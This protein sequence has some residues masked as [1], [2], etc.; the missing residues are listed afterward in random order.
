M[1]THEINPPK[2]LC[3]APIFE[4]SSQE[5][6]N[7]SIGE[8]RIAEAVR[9][10]KSQ[11][12]IVSKNCFD[13]TLLKDLR[14]ESIEFATK[15][16]NVSAESE[17]S[18]PYLEKSPKKDFRITYNF[19]IKGLFNSTAI[20]QNNFVFPI[21]NQLL[22]GSAVLDKFYVFMTVPGSERTE[23]HID[24]PNLFSDQCSSVNRQNIP[25]VSISAFIPLNKI[26]PRN[27]ATR[28]WPESH[29]FPM[30][31]VKEM[32]K[33][34]GSKDKA[35]D[36]YMEAGDCLLMD[37]RTVHQGMENLSDECRVIL[38]LNYCRPWFRD[39][40]NTYR[41][42]LKPMEEAEYVSHSDQMK[43]ILQKYNPSYYIN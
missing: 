39:T 22:G 10:F 21:V 33:C 38:L 43:F 35:F 13:S 27:G 7:Q 12:C 16:V 15:D 4:P 28:C 9:L 31:H 3:E 30:C 32:E 19:P 34:E 23:V 40:T 36:A 25:P 1:T 29:K 14:R 17:L 24:H 37:S 20:I 2:Q 41:V 8:S 5:L 6:E 42:H 11:G 18:K 26:T